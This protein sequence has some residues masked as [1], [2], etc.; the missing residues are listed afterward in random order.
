MADRQDVN[1]R[2]NLGVDSTVR[3]LFAVAIVILAA[4]SLLL[5]LFSDRADNPRVVRDDRPAPSER[6][7]ELVPTTPAPPAIPRG[8]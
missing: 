7:H 8:D 1:Q 4:V 2:Q 3:R 6:T 5:L